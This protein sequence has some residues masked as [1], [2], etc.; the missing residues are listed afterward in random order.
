MA[1]ADRAYEFMSDPMYLADFVP[2]VELEDSVAV[3]GEMDVDAELAE[4]G[5]AAHAGYVADAKTRRIEWGRPEADYGGSIAVLE[6]TPNTSRVTL[7]LHTR[8]DADAAEVTRVFEA[9]IA[10]IRRVLSGR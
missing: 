6:M 8:P 9:T 10:N 2:I 5:G 4:R 3:D 1:G 7:T